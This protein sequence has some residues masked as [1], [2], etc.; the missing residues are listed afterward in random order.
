VQQRVRPRFTAIDLPATLKAGDT[1]CAAQPAR[2][3]WVPGVFARR[4]GELPPAAQTGGPP[5]GLGARR[6][7]TAAAWTVMDSTQHNFFVP[8]DSVA[9]RGG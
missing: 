5:A 6:L 2:G 1:S 3:A 7:A 9:L 8:G 4:L